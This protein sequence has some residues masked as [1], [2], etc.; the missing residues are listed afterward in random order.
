MERA[1]L[2]PAT[3]DELRAF[4]ARYGAIADTR[5]L[6]DATGRGKGFGYVTFIFPE[7]AVSALGAAA[8]RN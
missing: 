7:A 6:R 8:A 4:F 1:L 2:E 3:D 5:I